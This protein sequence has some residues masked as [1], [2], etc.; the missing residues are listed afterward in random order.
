MTL[1]VPRIQARVAELLA[2]YAIP[3]AAIGVLHD[4]EL[5]EL[6]VGVKNMETQGTRDDGHR[7]PVRLH[8][9]DVDRTG[10]H[11]TRRRRESRPGRAGAELP[12][13]LRGGRSRG[14]RHKSPLATC[15]IH[16]NGIE[17]AY[18][19][20]GEDDDV[21]ARMVENIADA[22]QVFPLGHTHGYS[23]AL[24]YAI[25]ARILEVQDGE[26]WDD[27]M[28]HRLFDPMGL[29]STS[30]PARARGRS[31]GRDRAPD[32]VPTRGPH[33]HTGGPP[34]ARLRP[35]RQHHLD[36]RDVLAMAHVLLNEGTAPNGERIVSPESVREMMQFAGAR[37][38]SLHV[39]A[40][41]GTRPHRV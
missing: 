11:A 21:Y 14:K 10:L 9:Q 19:D 12:A 8:D 2:Q 24:G 35:R 16:T 30:T 13:R 25:L 32:P 40:G 17:E 28:R 22:P 31:P 34:A 39:R 3:S 15:C 7:L 1:D 23:A 37:T 27:I 20:P 5:T 29:T 33:R 26:R 6:A 4:G 18:G 38:G 41:M 36:V